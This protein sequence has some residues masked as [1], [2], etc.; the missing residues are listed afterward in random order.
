LVKDLGV[1]VVKSSAV[2]VFHPRLLNSARRISAQHLSG[3]LE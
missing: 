2:M 3:G 1:I